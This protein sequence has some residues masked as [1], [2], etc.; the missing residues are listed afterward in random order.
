MEKTGKTECQ[1]R[2]FQGRPG[3]KALKE[4][5][6][7]R[8]LTEKRGRK[9]MQFLVLLEPRELLGPQVRQV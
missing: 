2:V 1:C 9:D 8:V 5:L 3:H 4:L 7:H 6:A